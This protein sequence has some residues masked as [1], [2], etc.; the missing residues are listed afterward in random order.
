MQLDIGF[1]DAIQP[2]PEDVEY[3]TLLDDP[4]PH[5]RV[6]PR[7]AVIAEKF[8]AMVHL[9]E[10]NSRLKDFYDI[11]SL[12]AGHSFDFAA[13]SRSVTATFE[14]RGTP[15]VAELPA[16]LTSAFFTNE[17]RAIQWRAYLARGGLTGAPSSFDLVGDLVAS[18]LGPLWTSVGAETQVRQTWIRGGPW[19]S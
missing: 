2:P 3:P 5:I 6:Y 1:A 12:A 10:V 16:A 4:V 17:G 14:R 19:K 7:E 15:I 9:G 18:F 11:Y 8:H 13:L